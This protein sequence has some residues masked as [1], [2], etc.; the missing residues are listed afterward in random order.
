MQNY[1]SVVVNVLATQ[2]TD[3]VVSSA[4]EE[5]GKAQL[6]RAA[7]WE[8]AQQDPSVGL[9]EKRSG[10][11]SHGLSVDTIVDR[12]T[13][14][15]VDIATSKPEG[16]GMVRILPGWYQYA[17]NPADAQ[18]YVQP[19]AMLAALPGPMPKASPAPGPGPSP[20][21]PADTSELNAKL[22]QVLANQEAARNQQAADTA[23]LIENSNANTEKIQSQI[24]QLSEDAQATLKKAL[25][26]YLANRE[27]GTPPP[28]GGGDGEGEPPSELVKLLLKAL[29][30]NRPQMASATLKPPATHKKGARK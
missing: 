9:C 10:N 8:I 11:Q 26:L 14:E 18:K 28:G 20:Q 29:I 15:L 25:A 19:T 24:H 7:A 4:D 23:R 12:I 22:D 6:T 5:E 2:F 16:A 1:A 21:P 27:P 30:A 17:L 13:G 3:H